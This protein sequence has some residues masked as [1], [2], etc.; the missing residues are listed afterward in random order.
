MG[1]QAPEYPGTRNK[2]LGDSPGSS[3]EHLIHCALF[4]LWLTPL[5]AGAGEQE[6]G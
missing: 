3:D 2:G 1:D 5:L 4:V 6:S